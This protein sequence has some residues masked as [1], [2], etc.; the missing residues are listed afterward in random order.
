VKLFGPVLFYDLVCTARRHRFVLY[1]IH[2]Y[3]IIALV[4]MFL[5]SWIYRVRQ[6]G[7]P[8]PI[9]E[10]ASISA[11]FFYLFTFLQLVAVFLLI[12]AF[13]ASVITDE[14]IRR[15]LEYLFTTDLAN[16]E[17]ILSKLLSRLAN[18][19]MLLLQGLPIC[20]LIPFMGGVEPSIVLAGFIATGMTAV[21][22]ASLGV[23]AS[24]YAR[25]VRDAM[26]LTYLVTAVY[27]LF[28][29]LTRV[30]AIVPLWSYSFRLGPMEFVASDLLW[31]F[32]AGNPF[33]QALVLTSSKVLWGAPLLTTLRGQLWDYGVFHGSV[34]LLC[35]I[36]ASLRLRAVYRKQ[37]EVKDRSS[38]RRWRFRPA[39]GGS[40]MVWK[41]LLVENRSRA[42]WL[43]RLLLLMVV[44]ASF[45]PIAVIYSTPRNA[46]DFRV[47][48]GYW[49]RWMGAAVASLLL[50]AVAVRAAAAIS[51][52]R[53]RQTF[54][55]L[56]TTPLSSSAILFAKWLGSIFGV[57][58]GFV[59]L[60]TIWAIGGMLGGLGPGC[61]PLLVGGW[62]VYAGTLAVV[63]LYFSLIC[64]TSLHALVWTLFTSSAIGIGV[65]LVPVDS[66]LSVTAA[67][68]SG[69]WAQ[70]LMHLQLGFT[71]PVVLSRLLPMW[72]PGLLTP[73]NKEDWELPAAFAGL[74]I[75]IAG[76]LGLWTV[77][78]F[79]F[80]KLTGRE[81]VRQP[82]AAGS[83]LVVLA[84][85]V[86]TGTGPT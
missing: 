29:A 80:R 7:G 56:L 45:L 6:Y 60:G 5:V 39:V 84:G 35:T 4:A 55:S 49:S 24:V 48:I 66:L 70:R 19:L 51:G 26:M 50:L 15:T 58:W 21:S 52:E 18:L 17:I 23:L 9:S 83:T 73:G 59:W 36:W 20:A 14:K 13:T 31:W 28:S 54:D 40:P 78:L 25:R 69:P 8:L 33:L 72:Q 3:C 57:R 77:L 53:D 42:R 76:G 74:A 37:S 61:F 1:R 67:S 81:I 34:A 38:Q 79:H 65:L 43:G 62:F 46:D 27:L 82:E 22:M 12:P 85:S 63:G 44:L 10:N 64:R 41:E 75:W 71:P 32:D 11:S 47:Y 68:M 30:P 16:R 86:Q 2:A